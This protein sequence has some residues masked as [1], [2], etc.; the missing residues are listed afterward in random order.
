V[1]DDEA[2]APLEALRASEFARARA[3]WLK[4]FGGAPADSAERV[5]H[6]RFLA[7]RGFSHDVIRQL[8]RSGA[9]ADD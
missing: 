6:M 5:R 1:S 8:L 2:A 7:S 3:V 4:R 9:Q